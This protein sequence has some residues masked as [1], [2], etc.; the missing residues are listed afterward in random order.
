MKKSYISIAAVFT[1]AI[2]IFSYFILVSESKEGPEDR[3]PG[4][5]TAEWTSFFWFCGDGNLGELN[6]MLCDL[7]FLE[8]VD[9][10]DKINMVAILDKEGQGDT[11][12]LEVHRNG[13]TELNLTDI[14]PSWSDNEL[15]LGDPEPLKKFLSWGVNN[16]SA[17]KYN[18]HLVNHGGGW[19]GMCWDESSEDHLSLPE[20]RDFCEDFKGLTG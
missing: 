17:H 3:I 8:L 16:Y 2:L 6:M 4:D 20:I 19:R 5:E 14:D 7:H 9:D 1:V 15:N 12:L 13:S 10:S 11:Q 18:I